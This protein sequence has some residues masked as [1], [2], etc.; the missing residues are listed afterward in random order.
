VVATGVCTIQPTSA[1]PTLST[2]MTIDGATQTTFGGDTNTAGP[3]VVVNG[4]LA[5]L[6]TNGFVV[7]STGS[8]IKGLVINGF[9]G[10]GILL[11]SNGSNIQG[12]FIGTN[13][14]G[15]TSVSNGRGIGL[16][17]GF[18][19]NVIGGSAAGAGNLISGNQGDGI[20]LISQ[21]IVFNKDDESADRAALAVTANMVQGNRIG[22]KADG[23]TALGNGSSG[24]AIQV[25]S[26]IAFRPD[27]DVDAT[28]GAVVP[29]G[30]TIIGGINPGEGNVIAFNG[31]DGVQVGAASFL[32]ARPESTQSVTGNRISGNSIFSN[33]STVFDLGIDLGPDGVTAND[34]LDPDTGP[35][36]LQNFPVLAS[37]TSGAGTTTIQGTLNSEASK[38][39]RV[40]F[41]SNASCDA[42]GNG[43]G[44]VDNR[45]A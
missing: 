29:T 22:T 44:R 39:Y 30:T 10:S 9:N 40:E 11:Q 15:A 33:G 27:T 21:N 31:R 36:N 6:G 19:A 4:S 20:T 23:T 7:T 2:V 17:D 41:F 3:E 24:I 18:S 43:E 45:V 26:V 14:A 12:N 38:A 16:T 34:T 1:L 42:A 35:N 25:Q 8:T 37:A 32:I 5:G 13:A 28:E